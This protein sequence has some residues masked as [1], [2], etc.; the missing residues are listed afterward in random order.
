MTKR[1]E[2][3][4]LRDPGELKEG[5]CYF[6][7]GFSHTESEIPCIETWIYIGKNLSSH[8]DYR[9]DLW[10]FQDPESFQT[11][12]SFLN[13]APNIEHQVITA[14]ADAVI[15]FFSFEGLKDALTT[16]KPKV[17]ELK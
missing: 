15:G 14:D 3:C 8:D 16:L 4:M 7:L 11:H 10:Y 1:I 2:D 12:G 5:F 17:L 6:Q 13:L 9:D